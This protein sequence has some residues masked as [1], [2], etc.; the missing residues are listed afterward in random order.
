LPWFD[1]VASTAS[2]W[3]NDN[4]SDACIH[5]GSIVDGGVDV[6]LAMHVI[7]DDEGKDEDGGGGDDESV[8]A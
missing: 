6:I 5:V 1:D 2:P 4:D 8:T 3:H 7:G